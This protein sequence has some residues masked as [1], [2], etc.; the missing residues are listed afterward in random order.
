MI[1]PDLPTDDGVACRN[2]LMS[3]PT[4]PPD[5]SI[6]LT[7][8]IVSCQLCVV[9]TTFVGNS[10]SSFTTSKLNHLFKFMVN[11]FFPH[12]HQ[13][14]ISKRFFHSRSSHFTFGCDCTVEELKIVF[15]LS[16]GQDCVEKIVIPRPKNQPRWEPR[17]STPL[18][19]PF[20]YLPL[21]L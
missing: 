15:F 8:S 11:C 17:R 14:C 1:F 12:F 19:S 9:Y 13:V 3:I 18:L 20:L 6:D 21:V 2:V 16:T 5:L 4:I 7:A 10:A